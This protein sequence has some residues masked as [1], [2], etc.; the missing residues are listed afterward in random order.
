MNLKKMSKK[1]TKKIADA[2]ANHPEKK[3][4]KGEVNLEKITKMLIDRRSAK[5]TASEDEES[6]EG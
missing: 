3:S 4:K 6:D 2:L 5:N 1:Q